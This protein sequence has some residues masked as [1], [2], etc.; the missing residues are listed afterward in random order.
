MNTERSNLVAVIDDDVRVLT[1]LQSLLESFGYAVMVFSSAEKFLESGEARH[2]RCVVSDI[3]MQG[4][5][6]MDLRQLLRKSQPDLPVILITAHD[7]YAALYNLT[8]GE[9]SMVLEKPLNMTQLIEII[10]KATPSE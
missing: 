2:A 1:S 7:D 3:G 5:N 9:E 4:M 6:G 8:F 10:R